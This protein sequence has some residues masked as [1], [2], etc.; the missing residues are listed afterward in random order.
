MT[1]PPTPIR[2]ADYSSHKA[3]YGELLRFGGYRQGAIRRLPAA[4]LTESWLRNNGTF[5]PVLVPAPEG[6][7]AAAGAPPPSAL[8]PDALVA[9][10][11]PTFE[12]RTM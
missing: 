12:V 1:P 5:R 6:G 10:L 2:A 7:A 3:L 4:Q 9:A 8:T 11:G